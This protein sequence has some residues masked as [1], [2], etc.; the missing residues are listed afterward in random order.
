MTIASTVSRASYSGDGTTVAFN[1]GFKFEDNSHVQVVLRSALGVET[2]KTLTTHYTLTGAGESSGT[3]TMITAPSAGET[4]LIIRDAPNTQLS[5]LPLGGAFPSTTVEQELDLA[6]MR[7]QQLEEK[8]TRS[9]RFPASDSTSL[10]AELPPSVDRA[11]MFLTF[12]AD[13]EPTVSAGSADSLTVSPFMATVLDDTD[14]A[15]ARATLGLG[16]SVL[17][18]TGLTALTAP[19]VGD[20]L[21]IY[22]ASA[23]A[24]RKITLANLFKVIDALTAETAPATDDELALYDTSAGT[25]DKITLANM[26]KVVDAL[27]EDTSPDAAADFVLIYDTSASA[28]KKAKPTNLGTAGIDTVSVQVFTGDGTWTKPAGVK[29]AHIVCVGGGG[30]GGGASGGA[31]TGMAGGGGGGG[32]A[33]KILDVTAVTSAAVTVGAAG[34]AGNT[35]GSAGGAGEDTSFGTDCIGKG[36]SGGTGNVDD[37]GTKSGGAG[38]VA[39]TGNVT[40]A[41]SAG[42]DGVAPPTYLKPGGGGSPARGFGFGGRSVAVGSAGAVGT[43]YGGGGG[44]GGGGTIAGGAGTAGICIIYEYK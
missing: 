33:E 15:A 34:S 32:Y 26:L 42:Y 28:V 11:S 25:G 14:A 10:D 2:V 6:A 16:V 36:G 17:D 13:G 30:G 3:V 12:D 37:A 35:S 20:E 27:T 23:L 29:Y 43:G 22:D 7:D 21:P 1:T 38:G 40:I 8:I 41:G 9:L 4:L 39:G 19:A 24:N 5:S 18:I 31:S 44:G